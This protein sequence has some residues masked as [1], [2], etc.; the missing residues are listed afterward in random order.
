MVQLDPPSFYIKLT[1]TILTTLSIEDIRAAVTS[2]SLQADLEGE[3]SRLAFA[4][5]PSIP[6]SEFGWGLDVYTVKKDEVVFYPKSVALVATEEEVSRLDEIAD[7]YTD[8]AMDF[9]R[10][11]VFDS[12]SISKTLEFHTHRSTG[13]FDEVEPII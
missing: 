12:A 11:F 10:D 4:L 13:S 3:L 7:D 9:I 6:I 8:S 5:V 2:S 1:S